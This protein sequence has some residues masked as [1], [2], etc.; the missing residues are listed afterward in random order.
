MQLERERGSFVPQGLRNTNRVRPAF[1]LIELLVVL[2][3]VGILASIIVS[4][5]LR[6]VGAG[7]LRG[8]VQNLVTVLNTAKNLAINDN[9]ITHVRFINR[10]ATE[11][12]IALYRFARTSDALSATSEGA[13]QSFSNGSWYRADGLSYNNRVIPSTYT[14]FASGVWYE[15]NYDPAAVWDTTAITIKPLEQIHPSPNNTL[16]YN[17]VQGSAPPAL[18]APNILPK[19]P[20]YVP[21]TGTLT[22]PA[23]IPTHALLFFNPDG[24]ASANVTVFV[25]DLYRMYYI[26]VNKGGMIHSGLI[27]GPA[28]YSKAAN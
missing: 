16:Y 13:V 23:T 19:M 17:P 27:Q 5:S 21:V 2:A 24:T 18:D 28:D 22:P 8:E 7:K 14:K 26:R 10:D 25:R 15:T 3:I 20:T 6:M 11:Q 9:Q 12:G 4:T 1:T